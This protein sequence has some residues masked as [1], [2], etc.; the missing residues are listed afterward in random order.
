MVS[1]RRGVTPLVLG[2]VA[3]VALI[4]LLLLPGMRVATPVPLGSE[5]VTEVGKGEYALYTS[6]GFRWGEVECEGTLPDGSELRVRP[7]MTQ[8]GLL[9]PRRWSSSGSFEQ[10]TAGTIH[11]VCTVDGA[12]ADGAVGEFTVGPYVGFL[13]IVGY[14]VLGAAGVVLV[15][16]GAFRARS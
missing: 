14:V 9:L 5:L 13:H 2:A 15:L 11:V 4:G 1:R 12:V 10:T 16:V 7:D 8:Q 6:P 3:L